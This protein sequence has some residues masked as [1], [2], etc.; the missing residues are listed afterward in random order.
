[1]KNN[2]LMVLLDGAEDHPIPELGGKKP[3]EVANMPFMKKKCPYKLKTTGR[4]HTQYYLHEFFTGYPP[5]LSRGMIEAYGFKLR[6]GEGRVAYRLSPAIIEEDTVKWAYNSESFEKE[7]IE[8]VKKFVH[9][10]DDPDIGFY[11]SGKAVVTFKGESVDLP[12]AP[13]DHPVMDIPGALGEFVECICKE[14]GGKTDYPWGGGGV[15][16]RY[17]PHSCLNS[18]YSVSNSPVALGISRS[19]GYEAKFVDKM[20]DRFPV[21]KEALNHGNVFLHIDEVDEYSH[22]K[23][24]RKKIDILEQAD[25]LMEEHFSD[26]ENIIYFVDHGT[27]CVTGTHILM[28]VPIWTTIDTSLPNDSLIQ[29]KDVLPTLLK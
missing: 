2:V 1:M 6:M 17:D 25:R 23:D 27:S 22:K 5:E 15:C 7:L 12:P 28:D 13:D 8:C 20:E 29:L 9:I 19:F 14:M 10:L 21:A 24:Y 11:T 16:K 4:S 3:L 18:L 26:V